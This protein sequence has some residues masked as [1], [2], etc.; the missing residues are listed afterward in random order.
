[1]KQIHI[2]ETHPEGVFSARFTMTRHGG[3]LS[4]EGPGLDRPA[5]YSAWPIGAQFKSAE[6]QLHDAID[7]TLRNVVRWRA[8]TPDL[9]AEA[10]CG[11]STAKRPSDAGKAAAG[12]D[13]PAAPTVEAIA[14][15]AV[16][17]LAYFRPV[18]A[19][20]IGQRVVQSELDSLD[21]LLAQA[22]TLSVESP[23]TVAQDRAK[24]R[25]AVLRARDLQR[26]LNGEYALVDR[27]MLERREARTERDFE[28]ARADTLAAQLAALAEQ[29]EALKPKIRRAA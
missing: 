15:R 8:T 20:C 1:M 6:E 17:A 2:T 22:A 10:P 4:V 5:E 12:A 21:E 13:A 26:R 29:V 16:A 11:A 7:Y 9:P 14:K 19:S 3:I 18:L 24:R 27:L 25:R 23:P 28:R